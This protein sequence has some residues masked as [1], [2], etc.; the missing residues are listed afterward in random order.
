MTTVHRAATAAD[1][2]QATS[3]LREYADWLQLSTGIDPLAVLPG[4]A[5]E[6][7]SLT[8]SYR[9]SNGALFIATNAVGRAIGVVAIRLHD[10]G[11][12]ELKR[13]Y[14]RPATRG[15]GIADQL[16]S[17]AVEYARARGSHC[18]WLESKH[19]LMDAAI[20]VY[21]RNGF[22]EVPEPGRTM[23]F[24]GIIVMERVYEAAQKIA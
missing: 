9:S 13:M 14:V 3:L 10:D 1:F 6:V 16:I 15:G 23:Q 17:A 8:R 19:G 21:R 12:S 4:F 20:A 11:T 7:E 18:T 24:D 5:S 2:Q 22:V